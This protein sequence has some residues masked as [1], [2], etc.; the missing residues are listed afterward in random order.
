MSAFL[1]PNSE[2]P[3]RKTAVFQL[4]AVALVL[5]FA[6]IGRAQTDQIIYSDAF[7]NGWDS[8]SWATVDLSN[9]TPVHSGSQSIKVTSGPYQAFR[10]HHGNFDT[11]G[12]VNVVFWIHGGTSGGQTM[13]VMG[14][15]DDV[16][17]SAAVTIGPIAA[18][19]WQQ[20]VIPLS[21]IGIANATNCTGFWLQENTGVA[22]PAYY[23]DD[24]ALTAISVPTSVNVSVNAGSILRNVDVRHFSVNTA[25]WDSVFDTPTTIN[26]MIEAGVKGLRFPGGSA[27]DD[28]HWAT[29]KNDAGTTT[30]ATN[31]DMF[32]HVATSISAPAV[33]ITANYGSGTPQEA[34]DWVRYSNV[35][36]GYG[37]KYWE[38]GNENYGTWEMDH[39]TRPN[40][41]V[42]Y[43]TRFKDY[44]NQM[45]AIDPT[46]KIGCPV[47]VGEDSSANYTD[48]VVTNPR[49][50]LTHSGWTPVML[51]TM[52]NLGVTPDFLAY[53][54]YPQ[55]PGAEGDAG[56]LA[57]SA[58]W[59]SDAANLRQQLADYLGAAASNVELTCTENNSVYSSPGKQT[60][61][62]VNGLFM[63][64]SFCQLMKTE[65]T[66]MVWWDW[67]NGQETGNNNST[68]LYG[69][70]NY[71][72][73][74]V[75]DAVVPSLPAN[76]YPTYYALKL[77]QYFAR[78]GDQVVTATSSYIGISAHA[79]RHP[80]G[81]VSVL[82]INKH[83]TT[84]LPVNISITGY[85]PPTTAYLASY[86]KPQD[87]A[88]Q[89]GSGS[90]DVAQTSFTI[91]G[92]NF[93]YTAPAYSINS[94][95]F[96]P[97]AGTPLPP[98]APSNLAASGV[99]ATQLTLSWRDNSSNETGFVFDRATNSA[100]TANFVSTNTA[101]NVTSALITGLTRNT[102][103]YFRVRAINANGAS[104]NTSTLNVRTKAH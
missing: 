26:A 59:A 1:T 55:A 13:T 4:A 103:Y 39:N 36:K 6:N 99:T 90:A 51:A 38:V 88:A 69:W 79:V 80:D 54:Y 32:A 68:S 20:V 9:P 25:I 60:T 35:T 91:P 64:D 97:P 34:A 77:L 95:S 30:W 15:L 89:T 62:L 31:F 92:A 24:I 73:Y 2:Y 8:W 70:R 29:G 37:F 101:S 18:G 83:P 74:G 87:T 84:N 100:F 5:F 19:T 65:F 43:A 63:A 96:T 44:F 104:A 98:T 14:L 10:P 28:Y 33:F 85:T 94:I 23:V 58:N 12:Y 53:H 21:S 72:N 57:S 7:Q 86:G 56:L 11:N 76:R 47:V 27:S 48:E 49:T 42:T 102:T 41:P 50:G 78:P 66:S 17:Q 61:S 75:M 93:S 82:L 81:K 3:M 40:D 16:A 52:K 22:Q 67:R 71:G 45:K 46:I